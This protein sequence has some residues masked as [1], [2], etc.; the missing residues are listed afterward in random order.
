MTYSDIGSFLKKHVSDY[1]KQQVLMQENDI[2]NNKVAYS[3]HKK[4]GKEIMCYL[5]EKHFQSYKWLVYSKVCNGAFCKYC[6][7]L[8]VWVA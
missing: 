1:D 7:F 4:N 3:I 5:S 6:F 2:I 8:Q